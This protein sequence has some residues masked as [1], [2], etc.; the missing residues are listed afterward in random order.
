[1]I[2]SFDNINHDTK[3]EDTILT[4]E[5][6]ECRILNEEMAWNLYPT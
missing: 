2:L 6:L 3:V 4:Y 1:M 5:N